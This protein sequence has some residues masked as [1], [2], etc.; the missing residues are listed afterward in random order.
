MLQAGRAVTSPVFVAQ[1]KKYM[2]NIH[3]RALMVAA[4]QYLVY[5]PALKSLASLSQHTADPIK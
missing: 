3:T 4:A 1:T 2:Q 5:H